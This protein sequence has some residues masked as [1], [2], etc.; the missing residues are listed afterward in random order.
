MH[1]A[2]VRRRIVGY[3]LLGT[4][5]VAV[6]VLVGGWAAAPTT[7]GLI[8]NALGHEGLAGAGN[9]EEAYIVISVYNAAGPVSGLPGGSFSISAPIVAAG[10]TDV[11]KVRVYESSA[12]IYRIDVA[13]TKASVGWLKGT[14]IVSVTL[15]STHG[16]GVAIAELSVDE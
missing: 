3:V 13:P 1:E 7:E 14:Y 9:N 11:T 6:A 5:A 10:G 8:M 15:T 12:G 4:L 16:S 2:N